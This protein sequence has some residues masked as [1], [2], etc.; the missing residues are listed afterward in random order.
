VIATIGT[1]LADLYMVSEVS[2]FEHDASY[3]A[4]SYRP[5]AGGKAVNQAGA[6]ARLGGASFPIVRIGNDSFGSLILDAL[7]N[8]GVLTAHI[9]RDAAEPTGFVLIR[10]GETDSYSLA[11]AYG[12]SRRLC[13]HDIEKALDDLAGA[14]GAIVGLEIDRG[15]VERV[16]T[17]LRER[18]LF[19]VLDPY[20]PERSD[21]PLLLMA[22][23]ITPNR[24]EAEAITGRTIDSIFSAKLAVRD[25]LDAGVKAVCLKLGA[26]GIVLGEGSTVEHLAPSPVDPIDATAAGDVFAGALALC[27]EKKWS[28]REAAAF[29]NYASALT[30][31]RRGSYESMP[32]LADVIAFMRQRHADESL[33]AR[34]ESLVSESADRPA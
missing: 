1:A 22:D 24:D 23:V 10:P 12:A 29:A 28:L 14:A 33:L 19:V 9:V 18:G 32:H 20:P 4:M 13:W 25:I 31:T 26:E 27:L 8:D 11:V 34:A 2:D 15:L 6:I 30:V 21:T 17:F 7:A 5:S 16:M 3:A